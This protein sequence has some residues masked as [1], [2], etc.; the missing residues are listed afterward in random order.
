MSG[1]KILLAESDPFEQYTYE[2]RAMH[3]VFVEW[4]PIRVALAAAYLTVLFGAVVYF[5]FV[6]Q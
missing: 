2:P 5:F 3:S 4:P 6:Q 1:P